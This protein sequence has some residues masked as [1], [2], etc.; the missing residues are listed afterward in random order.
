MMD[1]IKNIN[2]KPLNKPKI[3]PNALLKKLP[4][5]I[6][7]SGKIKNVIILKVINEITKIKK[8]KKILII[9]SSLISI[10]FERILKIIIEKIIDRHHTNKFVISLIKPFENPIIVITK[11]INI[12]I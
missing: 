4:L 9:R 3:N 10:N 2:V 11:S 6:F 1:I 12:I 5:T 7:I 8:N